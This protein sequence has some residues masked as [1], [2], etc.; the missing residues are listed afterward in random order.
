MPEGHTLHRLAQDL[1]GVF[2]GRVVRSGS[3]QGR[4]AGAARLDGLVLTGADAVGKH[5]LVEFEDQVAHVHLGLYGSF[6]LTPGVDHEVVGQVRWRLESGST[7]DLRGPTACE[8]LTPPEVDALIERIGPDPLRGDADPD[9]A[10]RRIHASSAPIATLLMDQ[11]VLGGVG[12]VYR[13]EVLFRH[14][15]APMTAGRRV[16]RSRWDAIWADLVELMAE[17]V[18]TGRIDTVRPEHDPAVTGRPPRADDHGGEVYVY[19][20]DG[21]DCLVCGTVIR[22]RVVAGRNLFW[23]PSCQRGR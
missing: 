21:M 12:N 2:G 22:K 18:V 4:F 8:L 9:R 16:P 13:A 1:T 10:W 3:P 7:A 11:K 20:R 23:C 15:V 17:G 19:R 14:Q 6:S 5:L